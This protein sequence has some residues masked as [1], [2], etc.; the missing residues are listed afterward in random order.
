VAEGRLVAGVLRQAER[1]APR[2]E[3]VGHQQAEGHRPQAHPQRDGQVRDAPGLSD[4][5]AAEFRRLPQQ[6]VRVP[7]VDHGGQVA[8]ERVRRGP[9]E[10]ALQEEQHLP[11]AVER[12]HFREGG[13]DLGLEPVE[14]AGDAR[15]AVARDRRLEGRRRGHA[16]LVPGRL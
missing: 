7:R 10:D 14:P 4:G 2:R 13:R 3:G 8:E 16:H 5:V 15:E 9:A 6:D 12:L 11:R 1:L